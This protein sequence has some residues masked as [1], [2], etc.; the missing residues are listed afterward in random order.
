LVVVA[1]GVVADWMIAVLVDGAVL[2]AVVTGVSNVVLVVVGVGVVVLVVEV[3]IG[4]A[5]TTLSVTERRIIAQ[6][7]RNKLVKGK[8]FVL[9]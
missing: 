8:C 1:A 5:V 6:K 7:M 3:L 2:L 9:E 4:G